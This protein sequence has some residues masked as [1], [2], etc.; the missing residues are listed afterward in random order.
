MRGRLQQIF[1]HADGL[2]LSTAAI[3]SPI[4]TPSRGCIAQLVEQ[5]TLNQRAVGSN[6]TAPTTPL[7]RDR[8]PIISVPVRP[9]RQPLIARSGKPSVS[10]FCPISKEGASAHA[11]TLHAGRRSGRL[12]GKRTVYNA[13]AGDRGSQGHADRFRG[14]ADNPAVRRR[15]FR[16]ITH[17]Q[18]PN[19]PV[20]RQCDAARAPRAVGSAR[21]LTASAGVSSQPP[22]QPLSP[23]AA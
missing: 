3:L 7:S 22:P 15:V 8:A 11:D 21:R 10:Q 1:R 6:P 12:Y 14:A 19:R 13:L 17:I 2:G 20:R 23:G 5:L 18:T 9:N 16:P 4:W